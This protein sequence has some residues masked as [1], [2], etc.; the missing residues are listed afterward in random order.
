[1]TTSMY[2]R[3][4]LG[5]RWE[6]LIT[7][8]CQNNFYRDGQGKDFEF[9]PTNKTQIIMKNYNVFFKKETNGFSLFCNPDK[10]RRILE[11]KKG[12]DQKLIFLIRNKNNYLLNYTDLSFSDNNKMYYFNNLISSKNGSKVVIHDKEYV[13]ESQALR[14]YNKYQSI[15][16]DKLIKSTKL[17]DARQND[18]KKDLWFQEVEENS[19]VKLKNLSEGHYSLLSGKSSESF[20]VIDYIKEPM[21]G[22]L[23]LFLGDL[24]KEN[25]FFDKDKIDFKEY[26]I[27]LNARK[28][29]WKY[30][31]LSENRNVELKLDEVKVNYN[32]KNIDFTKPKKVTLSNGQQAFTIETKESIELKE[33]VN[34]SDKMEMKIKNNSKWLSKSV[35]IPKPKVKSV[36][37]D[38]E[39]NKIYSTTYI[40]L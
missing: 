36:K 30:F 8:K 9:I 26:V 29:F 14:I 1:M 38:R 33:A 12:T 4:N 17:V 28:T 18:L 37:P 5:F 13:N 7:I 22:I 20:Y 2:Q 24:P 31:I 3:V 27:N 15:K 6:K 16:L 21:W 32:G 19:L 34:V 39:S 11:I 35:K 40:Y 23:D 25:S 10:F